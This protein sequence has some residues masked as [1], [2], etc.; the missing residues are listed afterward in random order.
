MADS[1]QSKSDSDTRESKTV[2][3]LEV[4]NDIKASLKDVS[5]L[6]SSLDEL[7][8]T[9]RRHEKLLRKRNR[10]SSSSTSRS[11]SRSRKRSRSRKVRKHKRRSRKSRSSSPGARRSRRSHES[12]RES[13]LVSASV[14]DLEDD[15]Q[16]DNEEVDLSS[17]STR[18]AIEETWQWIERQGTAEKC[19]QVQEKQVFHRASSSV[20]T[21]SVPRF[22][23]KDWARWLNLFQDSLGT[24]KEGS[25]SALENLPP[26]MVTPSPWLDLAS[27]S[28]NLVPELSS[29]VKDGILIKNQDFLKLEK[30]TSS[31]LQICNFASVTGRALADLLQ[32]EEWT[33]QCQEDLLLF[34]RSNEI[35]LE[36]FM[37]FSGGLATNLKL[38]HRS[39]ALKASSLPRDLVQSCW[40]SSLAHRTL[41]APS[42]EQLVSEH[43]NSVAVTVKSVISKQLT[44]SSSR[45]STSGRGRNQFYSSSHGRGSFRGRRTSRGR[46][47]TRGRA[48]TRET[49]PARTSSTAGPK[50]HS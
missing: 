13:S 31:L 44:R 39:A 5:T 25:Y 15:V 27:A 17:L 45:Q 1:Q 19:E 4:L 49:V 33:D 9:Q 18:K 16:S 12:R 22:V 7:R 34:A 42:V 38:L 47:A 21:S 46:G 10:S 36:Q 48:F 43:N 50:Q 6:R 3:S 37:K 35:M 20:D 24:R 30:A 11:P 26:L 41:F 14:V 2:S 40:Q 32:S 23:D 28:S 29:S 8:Q